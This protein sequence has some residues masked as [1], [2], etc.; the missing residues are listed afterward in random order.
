MFIRALENSA[1][2]R[3]LLHGVRK[4]RGMIGECSHVFVVAQP[5]SSIELFTQTQP[6]PADYADRFSSAE[7]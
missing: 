4:G 2:R 3:G 1:A 6:V 5:A 7:R